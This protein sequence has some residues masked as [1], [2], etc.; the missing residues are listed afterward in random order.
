M[1]SDVVVRVVPC[2]SFKGRYER[3]AET[4]CLH[5]HFFSG[6]MNGI[7]RIWYQRTRLRGVNPTDHTIK[8]CCLM[9]S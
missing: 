5:L 9:M 6:R 7:L 1:E 4:Y 3:E 8:L 2:G